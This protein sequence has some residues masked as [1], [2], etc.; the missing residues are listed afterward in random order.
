[1]VLF[2]K[3]FIFVLYFAHSEE[4]LYSEP[5]PNTSFWIICVLLLKRR[6]LSVA[7]FFYFEQSSKFHTTKLKNFKNPAS[8]IKK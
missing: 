2:L 8:L 7:T 3:L 5:T 6:S 1:M 4:F